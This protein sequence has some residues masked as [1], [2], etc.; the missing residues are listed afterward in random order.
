[1]A[2]GHSNKHGKTGTHGIPKKSE[3]QKLRPDKKI[4]HDKNDAKNN[5]HTGTIISFSIKYY[6]MS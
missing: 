6:L 4:E 2:Q 5:D 3:P 1:V